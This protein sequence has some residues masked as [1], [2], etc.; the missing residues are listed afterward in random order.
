[1]TV[2]HLAAFQAKF[3][4]R[5]IYVYFPDI[6]IINSRKPEL[7]TLSVFC[8]KIIKFSFVAIVN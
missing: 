4:N 8:K 6:Q 5:R 3:G 2:W 7:I 1:M